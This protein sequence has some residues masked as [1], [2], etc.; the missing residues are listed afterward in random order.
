MGDC[1]GGGQYGGISLEHGSLAI[2]G[3]YR[4]G[5]DSWHRERA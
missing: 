2:G 1:G 4:N 3:M 5:Y